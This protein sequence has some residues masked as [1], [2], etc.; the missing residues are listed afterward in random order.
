[1]LALSAIDRFPLARADRSRCSLHGASG[2]AK[3]TKINQYIAGMQNVER[4]IISGVRNL[5]CGLAVRLSWWVL[6]AKNLRA[7]AR[8]SNPL[9]PGQWWP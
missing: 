6:R 2:S 5:R 9:M 3:M 7:P 4:D 1:M 8:R